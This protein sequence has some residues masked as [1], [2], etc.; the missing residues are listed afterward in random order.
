VVPSLVESP[1]DWVEI[2][3]GVISK[4]RINIDWMQHKTDKTA[5]YSDWGP[6]MVFWTTEIWE[7]HK[8]DWKVRC[9]RKDLPVV[10]SPDDW[11]TQDRV[12][13]RRGIDQV[14]W[15][16]WE[17][18]RWIDAAYNWDEGEIHGYRDKDDDTVVSVRCR[19]KDL[20]VTTDD[21]LAE[22]DTQDDGHLNSYG[23]RKE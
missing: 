17:S 5:G 12:P 19:R 7:R 23:S 6:A 8:Q 20:P 3:V 4:P 16:N 22:L 9:R 13:P 1:D 18:Y 10:E 14:H 15:S 11:V 2:D 21:S